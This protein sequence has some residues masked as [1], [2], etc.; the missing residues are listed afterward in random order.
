MIKV[1]DYKVTIRGNGLELLQEFSMICSSLKNA[2]P[3][4]LIKAAMEVGLEMKDD[5]ADEPETETV[6]TGINPK[7]FSDLWGRMMGD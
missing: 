5:M 7:D 6:D 2:L 1:E 3:D 4:L